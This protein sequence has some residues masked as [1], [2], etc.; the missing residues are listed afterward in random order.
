[1]KEL[2]GKTIEWV[3]ACYAV[4]PESAKILRWVSQQIID[5]FDEAGDDEFPLFKIPNYHMTLEYKWSVKDIGSYIA[6][7][8]AKKKEW[9]NI[10]LVRINAW[11]SFLGEQY[12]VF[13]EAQKNSVLPFAMEAKKALH[14]SLLDVENQDF[15]NSVFRFFLIVALDRFGYIRMNTCE[16]LPQW[17]AIEIDTSKIQIR[18]KVDG[19]KQL[20]VEV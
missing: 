9:K 8:K 18:G 19:E 20:I 5:I 14:V 7:V 13:L 2:E 16:S 15:S 4:T 12:I 11:K 10:D 6:E 3:Y 1:M 17:E